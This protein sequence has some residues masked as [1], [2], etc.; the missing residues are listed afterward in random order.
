MY[1]TLYGEKKAVPQDFKESSI[2]HPFKRTGNPQVSD[3]HQ[4]ISL[5]SVVGKI[6]A[7]VLLNRLNEHLEQLASIRKPVWIREGQ[8]NN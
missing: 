4:G 1:F 3:S 5:L 6:L 2:I 7:R 8:R